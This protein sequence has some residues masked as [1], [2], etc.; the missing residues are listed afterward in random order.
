MTTFI[1]LI[2]LDIEDTFLFLHI[3]YIIYFY[4]TIESNI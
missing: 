2:H 3:E 4:N 1:L